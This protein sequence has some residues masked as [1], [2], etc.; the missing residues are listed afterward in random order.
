MAKG[1]LPHLSQK[2]QLK[3]TQFLLGK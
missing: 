2:M 3:I 1:Q